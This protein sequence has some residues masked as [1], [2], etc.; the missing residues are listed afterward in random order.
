VMFG[1]YPGVEQRINSTKVINDGQWHH[2]VS[3]LGDGGMK[4]YVDGKLEAANPNVKIGENYTGRWKIGGD[5]TWSGSSSDYFAG[6]FDEAAVYPRE[7]A[8]GEVQDHYA[9]SGRQNFNTPP[10]STF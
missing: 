2:V 5:K 7:L 1:V 8:L 9:S 4:L 10:V 6:E 3:S